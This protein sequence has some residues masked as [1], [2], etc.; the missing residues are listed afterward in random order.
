[1]CSPV[2]APSRISLIPYRCLA[3]A[4]SAPQ[5]GI[6]MAS[7]EDNTCLIEL[8]RSSPQGTRLRIYSERRDYFFRST[9]YGNQIRIRLLVPHR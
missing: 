2:P 3:L 8:E 9:L 7:L 6:S 5:W 4:P 1:M